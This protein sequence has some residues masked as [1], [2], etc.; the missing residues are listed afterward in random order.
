MRWTHNRVALMPVVVLA[1]LLWAGCNDSSGPCDWCGDGSVHDAT[2][3]DA[4]QDGKADDQGTVDS[5]TFDGSGDALLDVDQSSDGSGE[6][7]VGTCTGS[8]CPTLVEAKGSWFATPSKT[9]VD[10][11]DSVT[12][13]LKLKNATNV[14]LT[15]SSVQVWSLPGIIDLTLNNSN[16]PIS[17]IAVGAEFD[18]SFTVDLSSLT[19]CQPGLALRPVSDEKGVLSPTDAPL[20]AV[21]QITCQP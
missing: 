5:A 4:A 3:S 14:S 9:E 2:G 17:D 13:D 10:G 19:T 15:V 20:V 12:F 7:A 6:A 11:Y 21:S 18:L 8:V 16:L 1:V